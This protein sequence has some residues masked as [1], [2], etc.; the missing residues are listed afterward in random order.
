ML[1]LKA[2]VL[3]AAVASLAVAPGCFGPTTSG[4][5]DGPGSQWRFA[6]GSV[7]GVRAS[8]DPAVA[9]AALPSLGK[10]WETVT[11]GAVTGTP[12]AQDGHVFVA[13]WKGMVYSLAIGNGSVAWSTDLGA[14]ADGS[15]TLA[16]GLALV[17][18]AKGHLHA[19]DAGTGETVWD[20]LVDDHLNVH[21]Y[22]T[23]L[24]V[25]AHAGRASFIVQ[26]VGSDQ[27]SW[28]LQ[29]DKPIDFR[30][31]LV[32]FSLEGEVL[33]RSYFVAEGLTGAPVWGTP[34]YDEGTDRIVVGTGNAYTAPAGELT[35]S[36]VAVA[37]S[38]GALAWHVQGL[39]N[40]VFTQM[41]PDSPDSD[42]GATPVLFQVENRTLA[43]IGQKSAVFWA[44]DVATGKLAW[45]SGPVV[46]GEGVLGDAALAGDLLIVPYTNLKQV[47]AIRSSDGKQLWR[48]NLTGVGYSDP[49]AVDGGVIV[50]DGGGQV[51]GLE[52]A[53]GRQVW[54]AQID[55]GAVFGGL[56]VAQGHLLVPVVRG[57]FLGATGGVV[58]FAPQGMRSTDPGTSG[59]AA[60][61][62]EIVMD[63][64][65][66]TPKEVHAAAGSVLTLTNRDPVTHTVTAVD[67]SFDVTVPADGTA[68]LQ[69]GQ[70]GTFQ[71][72]CRPHANQAAD[73]SWQGMTG[74]LVV[75]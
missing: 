48:L 67:G 34:V 36:I 60:P 25:P 71:F 6:Q 55:G 32:A 19:L 44:V 21:L 49:V 7:D 46:H 5:P 62:H 59:A 20:R 53:T 8:R 22:S 65:E 23:P 28:K 27:E 75:E 69:V 4:T 31:H 73:G 63:G 29:G 45:K 40:D 30:G 56:S 72:Y 43:G 42:F 50:A 61:S 33:W 66:F 26:G 9:L 54:G 1:S 11:K 38:D 39:A 37:A 57:G 24:V 10:A 13:T 64:F 70:A 2:A 16:E 17:G 51:R 74:T 58:A 68:Q 3:A 14:Q 12:T 47:A 18:D 41:D 35:D 15:V 52:A